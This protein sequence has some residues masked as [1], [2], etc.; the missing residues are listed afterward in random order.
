MHELK[1]LELHK[2]K[3]GK[4]ALVGSGKPKGWMFHKY[5]FFVLYSPRVEKE[6]SIE[7]VS[8]CFSRGTR[9]YMAE[10]QVTVE[11][12]QRKPSGKRIQ[13]E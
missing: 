8:G 9:T 6:V 12:P 3:D 10:R 11:Q 2:K 5:I 7:T 13:Q 1:H 4:D